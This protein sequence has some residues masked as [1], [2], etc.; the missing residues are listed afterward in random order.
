MEKLFHLLSSDSVDI[1]LKRSAAEQLSVVLQGKLG[2]CFDG[3][4]L[5]TVYGRIFLQEI[6]R[7]KE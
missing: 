7:P 3:F 2:D 1:S 6:K 4:E 5:L